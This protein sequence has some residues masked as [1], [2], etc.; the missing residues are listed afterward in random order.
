M[1]SHRRCRGRQQQRR[2][3]IDENTSQLHQHI[4][5]NRSSKRKI[6]Y[7]NADGVLEILE[8]KRTFWCMYYLCSP[9]IGDKI[10]ESKFRNRFRLPYK[11]F[12]ELIIHVQGY[13]LFKRWN[14]K[15][16]D[17]SVV[18]GLILLGVVH[19]LGRG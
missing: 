11:S 7:V 5:K 12:T 4:I 17:T 2:V 13:P 15:R 19:Y 3:K 14:H 18:L 1:L 10:F 8:P 16:V 6:V 9:Q